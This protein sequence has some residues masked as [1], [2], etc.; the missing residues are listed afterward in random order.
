MEVTSEEGKRAYDTDDDDDD[1]FIK[2]TVC[3]AAIKIGHLLLLPT[4]VFY[5]MYIWLCSEGNL[6]LI[7]PGLTRIKKESAVRFGCT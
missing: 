1:F 3:Y 2:P 6:Q 4:L 7:C 5:L